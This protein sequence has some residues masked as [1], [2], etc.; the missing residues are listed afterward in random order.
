MTTPVGLETPVTQDDVTRLIQIGGD[1]ALADLI[2]QLARAYR[3]TV[4]EAATLPRAAHAR[5][6]RL[7]GQADGLRL[8]LNRARAIHD[9]VKRM[10]GGP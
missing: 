7:Q 8:A 1:E 3:D 9:A 10:P 2:G 6:H 4:E 5:R